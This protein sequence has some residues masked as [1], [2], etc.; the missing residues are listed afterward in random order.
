M[1]I[2][3]SS[4]SSAQPTPDALARS[5]GRFAGSKE[6]GRDSAT[7][8]EAG[9]RRQAAGDPL[10]EIA[11]QN[12]ASALAN[13]E[14]AQGATNWLKANFNTAQALAAQA[15]LSPQSVKKALAE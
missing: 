8:S 14:A 10:T 6:A 3:S 12:R 5:L 4:P 1:I 9:E 15:N 7:L 13:F 2:P 11:N